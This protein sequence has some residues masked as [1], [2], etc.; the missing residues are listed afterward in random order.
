MRFLPVCE[1][2]QESQLTFAL[3]GQIPVFATG[4]LLSPSII[5][6][7]YLRLKIT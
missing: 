4:V 2:H 3:T 6:S 5:G 7:T 1:G